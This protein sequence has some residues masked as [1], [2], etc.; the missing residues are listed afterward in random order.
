[1]IKE[2]DLYEILEVSPKASD[3][4]I[5]NAYRTLAKK[6]HPDVHPL[7]TQT[8]AEKKLKEIN[9]AYQIIGNKVTKEEY[10][11]CHNF[12]VKEDNYVYSE[13]DPGPNSNGDLFFSDKLGLVVTAVCFLTFFLLFAYV[14]NN[15][16]LLR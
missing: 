15:P 16:A 6:W 11:R 3:E 14:R 10:D 9:H 1:L 4:V 2:R 13:H 5:K 8:Q 12:T 7:G